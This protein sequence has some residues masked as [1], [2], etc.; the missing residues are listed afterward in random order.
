MHL[1]NVSTIRAAQGL[2]VDRVPGAFEE[3]ARDATLPDEGAAGHGL[4]DRPGAL[5]TEEL[6]QEQRGGAEAQPPPG[7]DTANDQA[8]PTS[9]P[10]AETA[11]AASCIVVATT[12]EPD[13]LDRP[14]SPLKRRRPN[15]PG[16]DL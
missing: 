16:S 6:G 8:A 9:S 13:E 2:G 3:D 15:E 14:M 5:P 1:Y 10:A 11:A 4:E 12:P 7:R